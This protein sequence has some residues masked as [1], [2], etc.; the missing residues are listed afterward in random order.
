MKMYIDEYKA[1]IGCIHCS[2]ADPICLDFHHPDSTIKENNISDM[3]TKRSRAYIEEEIS[4]C[5]VICSNCH[6]KEHR[7]LREASLV[8]L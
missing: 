2:E 5:V 8:R 6:R 3:I 1:K 7:R 4:R